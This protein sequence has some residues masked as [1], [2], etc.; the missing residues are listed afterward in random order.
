M[1][2]M[3]ES[4]A[5]RSGGPA[6]PPARPARKQETATRPSHLQCRWALGAPTGFI[7]SCCAPEGAHNPTNPTAMR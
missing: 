7:S 1:C 4:A 3:W 2:L 5:R 6:A